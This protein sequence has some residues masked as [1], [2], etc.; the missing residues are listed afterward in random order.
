MDEHPHPTIWRAWLDGELEPAARRAVQL[1][2]AFCAP[3][4][5]AAAVSSGLTPHPA[6]DAAYEMPLRRAF[7]VAK[8]HGKRLAAARAQARREAAGSQLAPATPF[9]TWARAEHWLET[10]RGFRHVDAETARGAAILAGALAGRLA[11]EDFPAGEVAQLR[12]DAWVELANALRIAGNLS[13]AERAFGRA[14]RATE[15][16]PVDPERG[17]RR[18]EDY[19]SFLIY[20]RRYEEAA[21]LLED[22][23]EGYLARRER[24]AAGRVLIRLGLVA[25]KRH[26]QLDA[27]RFLARGFNYLTPGEEPGLDLAALHNL[28][29]YC[30]ELGAPAGAAM[31]LK[32]A[33]PLYDHLGQPLDRVKAR[34]LG[35][36]IAAKRRAW[37]EAEDILGEVR[38]AYE[39]RGLPYDCALVTLDLSAVWLAQGRHGEIFR[40]AEAMLATF[41]AL[42]IAPEALAALALLH[43]AAAQESATLALI[44]EAAVRLAPAA[45]K[46]R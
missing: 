30:S 25:G 22:I 1:H 13:A 28:I 45:T 42:R 19:A 29:F 8:R 3:C 16:A 6:G 39:A 35:G 40:A 2:L 15:D 26:Q 36:K 20:C 14:A 33:L 7:A 31:L 41:R 43:E 38:G 5:Q 10:A 24:H 46:A 4:R 17:M 32:K 21:V 37:G 11:P 12:A 23:A 44:E 9:L 34:W 27:L 18:A